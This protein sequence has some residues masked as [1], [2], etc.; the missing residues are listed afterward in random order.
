V[1]NDDE[2]IKKFDKWKGRK[3]ID[4]VIM[5]RKSPQ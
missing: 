1:N 3:R 4:F 2:L 5:E